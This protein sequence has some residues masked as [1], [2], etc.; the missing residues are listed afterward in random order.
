MQNLMHDSWWK[1][2]NEALA[3]RGAYNNLM[4]QIPLNLY[5]IGSSWANNISGIAQAAQASEIQNEIARIYGYKTK[6]EKEA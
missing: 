2:E 4:A 6:A 5:N 1:R 3:K